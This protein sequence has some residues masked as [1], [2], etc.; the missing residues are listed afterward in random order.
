ML[1]S[2]FPNNCCCCC[3]CCCWYCLIDGQYC[4]LFALC[5]HLPKFYV[6]L[7]FERQAA[8]AARAV[9]ATRAVNAAR[10]ARAAIT[11]RYA[12]YIFPLM[13]QILSNVSSAFLA[14]AADSSTFLR[15]NFNLQSHV[16]RIKKMCRDK[17]NTTRTYWIEG[18]KNQ[19]RD[20]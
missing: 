8:K 7:Q 9:R 4:T 12:L 13:V 18:K 2:G 11:T 20:R 16:A 1:W 5:M 17:N 10:V 6:L 3:W 15:F 14:K 19:N